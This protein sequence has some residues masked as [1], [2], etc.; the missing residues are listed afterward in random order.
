[1]ARA[2]ARV[3]SAKFFDRDSLE[4]APELLNK[5]LVGNGVSARLVEVEA[6]RADEDPGSHSFRG[7]TP[8]TA[9]M[10]AAP[11]TLYVYFSYGNHWCMNAV[12]GPGERASAVLLRAAAPVDGLDAMRERRIK[13]TRDRDLAAGPGRLGQAFAADRSLDGTNLQRGP[14][15]IIDDGTPPPPRPGNSS[16]I[17]LAAGKGE[18][19]PY[20]FYV[21]GDENISRPPR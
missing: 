4:V 15:Q 3:V 5:I 6:Y 18:Q 9:A 7:R 12:C 14:L 1:V 16:R 17:G 19:L 21:P 10:F 20:R 8:R 2:R 13:A 11:G